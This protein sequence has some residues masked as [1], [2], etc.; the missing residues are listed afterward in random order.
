MD[1]RS[2]TPIC[3]WARL[4]LAFSVMG[5]ADIVTAFQPAPALSNRH[6][7]RSAGPLAAMMDPTNLVDAAAAVHHHVS[8]V[9]TTTTTTTTATL[10]HFGSSSV[11]VSLVDGLLKPAHGHTQP[12]FGPPDKY[13]SAG[14]SIAP[15]LKALG[16]AAITTTPVDQ[17]PQVAQTAAK[18]GYTILEAS[19]F[20]G[21][22]GSVLP[23]FMPTG[24]ILPGHAD[25]PDYTLDTFSAQVVSSAKYLGVL[26]KLPLI[27]FLYVL[28]DFFVLDF[29]GLRD[30]MDLYKEDIEDEPLDVAA[31]TVADTG[32][33]LATF[34][35]ISF[36]TVV[37][38]G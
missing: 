34:T 29:F 15:N 16:D 33:R 38:F 36:F 27:A 19:K 12:L 14:N 8:S 24:G 31:K 2:Q 20:E 4:S 9:D 21:G 26:E 32:V 25:I 7:A 5:V 11:Y 13:L 6:T 35:A 10:E 17:L 28:I 1:T 22:G 30:N 18:Q 3:L 23:G 37:F